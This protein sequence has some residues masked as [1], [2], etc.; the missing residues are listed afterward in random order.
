M[1]NETDQH[2]DELKEYRSGLVETQRKLNESYDKLIIT[3]SGGSLALSITFL[4]DIIGSNQ[5][6]H[7]ILLL[8]AWGLFVLSLAA[9][10]GEILF[11]IKAHKKA[12]IQVDSGTIHQQKV[13]GKSSYISTATH[14]LAAI[15]LVTGLLFIS[16]FAYCNLGD[17]NGTKETSTKA[18]TKTE[19][20]E[21]S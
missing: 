11:G 18:A 3:L 14:W 1:N 13:G 17:T 4:K 6:N 12:I 19:P 21:K 2:T 20:T 8:I 7:P 10:L 9:V 15:C 5:I 16:A